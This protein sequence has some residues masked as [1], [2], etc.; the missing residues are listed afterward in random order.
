MLLLGGMAMMPTYML[1]QPDCN[2]DGHSPD[3]PRC[4]IHN[5]SAYIIYNECNG[6]ALVSFNSSI[7]GAE[8]LVY[9]DGIEVDYYLLDAISGMQVPVP[10]TAYGS[11]EF[12][13]QV[14]SGSTLLAILNVTL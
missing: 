8:I 9:Q 7:D 6:I 10:L 11:G 14:K 4:P 3:Y 5:P 1:A 2:D 12:V 13:I